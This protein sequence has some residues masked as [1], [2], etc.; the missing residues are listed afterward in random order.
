M[1]F[2]YDKNKYNV[3]NF[4][5]NKELLSCYNWYSLSESKI[6]EYKE[7]KVNKVEDGVAYCAYRQYDRNIKS[8]SLRI[9]L[10]DEIF[11][12]DLEMDSILLYYSFLNL[13]FLFNKSV[14]NRETYSS[15]FACDGVLRSLRL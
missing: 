10:R 7:L 11:Y 15:P 2:E 12:E 13:I 4:L 3:I 9:T 14:G 8:T 1:K 6:H 5:D